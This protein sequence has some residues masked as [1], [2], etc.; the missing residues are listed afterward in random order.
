MCLPPAAGL[1]L[2]S[3]LGH[4]VSTIDRTIRGLLQRFRALGSDLV[5]DTMLGWGV[6]AIVGSFLFLLIGALTSISKRSPRLPRVPRME[7]E[8]R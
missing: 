5:P 6:L 7:N 8:P 1:L 3:G 2:A 4:S